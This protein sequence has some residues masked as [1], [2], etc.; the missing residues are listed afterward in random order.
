[1]S[2]H[3]L[4]N[5]RMWW[6]GTK[7]AKYHNAIAIADATELLDKTTLLDTVRRRMAG[8]SDVVCSVQ[9]FVPTNDTL[10]DKFIYDRIGVGYV[11]FSFTAEGNPAE[12]SEIYQLR[13]TEEVYIQQLEAQNPHTYEL[14]FYASEGLFKNTLLANRTV[15]ADGNGPAFNAGTPNEGQR[16]ALLVHVT[17]LS[18]GTL[19]LTLE[20]DADSS[21]ASPTVVRTLSSATTP[22]G[23]S[24]LFKLSGNTDTWWRLAWTLTGGSATFLAG[25][26]FDPRG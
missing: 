16:C 22:T 6:G 24:A 4:N 2:V 10:I 21:F 14:T 20:S 25:F 13:A 11:P 7:A 8:L 3:I 26:G 5:V 9:G 15:T 23:L 18:G 19:T 12:G 17:A 1:M